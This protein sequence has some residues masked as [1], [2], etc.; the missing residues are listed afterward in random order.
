M[1]MSDIRRDM[2]TKDLKLSDFS[3]THLDDMSLVVIK[4]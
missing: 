3:P 1:L 4:V 2:E